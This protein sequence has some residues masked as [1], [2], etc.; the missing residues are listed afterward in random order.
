MGPLAGI[1]ILEIKGIGPGPYAGMLLAD[2]G[3]EVV[4]VERSSKHQGIGMPSSIDPNSRG[5]R[6]IA[7]D[8]KNPAGIDALL[9]LIDTADVLFEGFRPGVTE[10][11][12]FGP[13][14]CLQRNPK[15]VYGRITGWG[16]TGPLAQAAGHDINYISLT[17]S[18][19]AI[20]GSDR[21]AIPLN[22]IGD[23][24]GGSMFLVTGI[25]AALIEA[26]KTGSGQVVD[27]AMTDGSASLMTMVHGLSNLGAW[28]NRRSSNMLDGSA[29]FYD[30]YETSDG[31]FVSIGSI[32]PQFYALLIEK[33]ELDLETFKEQHSPKQ[34]PELKRQL[35][36]VIKRKTRDEWCQIMEGTD[37]CF[38]PVLDYQEAPQH[39]HNKDRGTYITIN[40]IE[41]PAPAPRFS[42]TQ[43]ETPAA[44]PAEGS[45]TEA[46]LADWGFDPDAIKTAR[47]SGA[48][49]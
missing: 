36:D 20:G 49:T 18:L 29:H 33:A 10:R 16:Q 40:D 31:K 21:P 2:M 41:Q 12:G 6:S 39:P 1:R 38:A 8:L 9:K 27:A 13:E 46:V 48:L 15:L 35:A 7:L 4:V 37:I 28:S 47:E 17:G 43:C 34:W 32:E 24:A 22:L 11:L 45:D 26:N 5:K 44:P 42:R 14:V 25:L 23:F 3:A 30:V 19:A